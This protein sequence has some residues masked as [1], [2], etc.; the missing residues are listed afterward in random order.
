MSDTINRSELTIETD[1]CYAPAQFAT[2]NDLKLKRQLF[3]E[4]RGTVGLD[5]QYSRRL[6]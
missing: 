6:D 2:E 4:R 1:A 3:H 5:I